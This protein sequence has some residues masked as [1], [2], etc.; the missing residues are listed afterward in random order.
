MVQINEIGAIQNVSNI[1]KSSASEKPQEAST[2]IFL[3]DT[4]TEPAIISE[5][6]VKVKG[7]DGKTYKAHEVVTKEV[8]DA[9][10]TWEVAVRTYTDDAGNPVKDTIKSTTHKERFGKEDVEIT[11]RKT[12]HKTPT[13]TKTVDSEESKYH[14]KEHF[15]EWEGDTGKTGNKLVPKKKYCQ[16][17]E[18]FSAKHLAKT[19]SIAT[20]NLGD[21]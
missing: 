20:L 9:G 19:T 17:P 15:E 10:K 8:D 14:Y 11:T 18:G 16:M 3:G 12:V 1:G 4:K 7:D 6:E 5:K 21:D 13:K 2:S